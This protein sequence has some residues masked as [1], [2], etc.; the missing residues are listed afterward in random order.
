MKLKLHCKTKQATSNHVNGRRK[1]ERKNTMQGKL[2]L[3][4]G[5]DSKRQRASDFHS[6]EHNQFDEDVGEVGRKLMNE[7]ERRKK[8]DKCKIMLKKKS[9]M[10]KEQEKR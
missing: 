9:T 3:L 7:W 6:C 8:E 2:C 1:E 10:T 5:N 4:A